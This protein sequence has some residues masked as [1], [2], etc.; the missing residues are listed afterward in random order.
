MET[1]GT[2][3][4]LAVW[5]LLVVLFLWIP[6]V[7]IGVYAF[8][9]SNIQSWPIPG[10]TTHW[11]SVAWHNSD[12][13]SSLWLSVRVA[14]LDQPGEDSHADTMGRAPTRD[15]SNPTARTDC[16]A[17]T[18]LKVRSADSPTH[19]HKSINIKRA[20]SRRG[21]ARVACARGYQHR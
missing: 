3:I 17:V 9:A 18:R 4:G 1:R 20:V 11:F 5:A 14:L 15:P 6:L 7:L 19:R 16:I 8:N 10:W 21:R 12:V 13:R 2:R